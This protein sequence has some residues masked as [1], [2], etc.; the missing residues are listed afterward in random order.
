VLQI[1]IQPL[2]I[3]K[4]YIAVTTTTSISTIIT[5]IHSFNAFFHGISYSAGAVVYQSS[6]FPTRG[7][8]MMGQNKYLMDAVNF[9]V[10]AVH[11]LTGT[12][13]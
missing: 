3:K 10:M 9:N 2:L 8:E 5:F 6:A 11:I 13:L 1:K 7:K 4:K 12:V